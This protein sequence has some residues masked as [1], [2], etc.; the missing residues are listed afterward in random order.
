MSS[1]TKHKAHPSTA[2]AHVVA[3]PPALKWCYPF[4]RKGGG[5]VTD[6]QV[7]YHALG[8]MT[9]GF[10]PLGVNGFPHGGVHFGAMS[11]A[12]VDQSGGVRLHADGEI[13]AYRI[14]GRYPHLKFRQDSR[15][16]LYSTGFVLVRHRM[17]LPPPPG[18]TAYRAIRLRSPPTRR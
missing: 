3:P 5:E 7:F 18:H 13:V 15:W 16:A 6:P 11:A 12:C 10:F 9:D 14:D 4:P 2:P 1:Q 8:Q 17:T